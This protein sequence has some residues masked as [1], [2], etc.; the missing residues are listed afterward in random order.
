VR[1]ADK[2]WKDPAGNLAQ[3]GM[4]HC[5]RS[6]NYIVGGRGVG[7]TAMLVIRGDILATQFPGLVGM[8]TEQTNRDIERVLIPC[9]QQI[10]LGIGKLEHKNSGW[11]VVYPNGSIIYFASRHAK[12]TVSDPPFHGMTVG[13]LAHDELSLDRRTDVITVSGMMVRQQGYPNIV[14][15]SATPRR[16]WLY[17]HC[18]GKG[19]VEPGKRTVVSPD[20]CSQIFYGPTS[21]NAYNAGLHDRMIGEISEHEAS[22]YLYGEWVTA[23]GL[24][25]DNFSDEEWPNGNMIDDGGFQAGQP[26]VLSIDHGGNASWGLW[27]A[28]GE[29][30]FSRVAEYTPTKAQPG[31]RIAAEIEEA[32][33][34]PKRII[35]GADHVTGGNIGASMQ[36]LFQTRGWVH[37]ETVTGDIA[38]KEL[39]FNVLQRNLCNTDGKRNILISRQMK[40]HY[41]GKT[42]GALECFAADTWP[43]DGYG[44]FFRKEKK[45]SIFHEDTRDELL[46]FA[47]RMWRPS[48][49]QYTN[50]AA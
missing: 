10:S 44:H 17:S 36:Q 38:D 47:V 13:W 32:Y 12:N 35:A 22:Q 15:I 20:L 27:Q 29:G 49:S 42:R 18:L 45:A 41:P 26:Y 37:A 48:W 9:W 23:E 40:C 11:Q 6:W 4:L 33:G 8:I 1:A 28:R 31:Y 24:I 3:M 39:Q 46:Y 14:D 25:W 7:K 43:D 5:Y 30:R 2:G 34:K 50:W 21:E 19:L 16:N